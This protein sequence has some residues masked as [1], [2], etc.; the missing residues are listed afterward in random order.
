LSIDIA[1][2]KDGGAVEKAVDMLNPLFKNISETQRE[3]KE[4]ASLRD[5]LLPMLMNGQ[6]TVK[7]STEPQ[8]AQHG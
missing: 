1:L 3:N 7:P 2:P 8:E 6:V 5:W 4:L